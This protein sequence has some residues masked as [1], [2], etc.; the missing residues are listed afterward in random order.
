MEEREKKRSADEIE[1][2]GK[3]D[4]SIR[5]LVEFLK[6]GGGEEELTSLFTPVDRP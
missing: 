6:L 3:D 2:G 4:S 1:M 5:R